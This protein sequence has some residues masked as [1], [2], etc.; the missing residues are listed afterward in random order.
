MDFFEDPFKNS[1]Y[2]YGDPFDLENADNDPF[3]EPLNAPDNKAFGSDPF[4]SDPFKR[5]N[6]SSDPFAPDNTYENSAHNDPFSKNDNDPFSG[7]SQVA[8]PVNNSIDPFGS[9]FTSAFSGGIPNVDPFG[10]NNNFGSTANDPFSL[11]NLKPLPI[12]SDINS[13]SSKPTASSVNSTQSTVSY[14][15]DKL[16]STDSNS[17]T[18]K[19]KRSS[20]SFADLL[21]GSTHKADK[22]DKT[23]EKKDKKHGKFHLSSPLKTHKSKSTTDSPKPEKKPSKN[24]NGDIAPDEVQLKMAAELSKKSDDD[25]R[26]KLQLQE[27]ADLAYAIALSKAEAASLNTQ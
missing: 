17:S 16:A 27:E 26:R 2:R 6:N 7:S 20:H 12:V 19:K 18:E 15:K 4:A 24:S 25:R 22:G 21:G 3:S 13:N 23:K 5:D 9:S 1:N 11:T 14:R 10:T 8:A